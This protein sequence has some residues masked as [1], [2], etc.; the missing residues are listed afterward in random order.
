MGV[1]TL[2]RNRI[3]VIRP[4]GSEWCR[5]EHRSLEAGEDLLEDIKTAIK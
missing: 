5:A 3:N 4:D 2:H 1:L